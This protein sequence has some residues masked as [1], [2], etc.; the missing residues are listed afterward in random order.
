MTYSNTISSIA[1]V[2]AISM[3]LFTGCEKPGP[4][5]GTDE[6]VTYANEFIHEGSVYDIASV[7]RFDQDNNTIQFWISDKEGLTTIDQVADA[8]KHLV[9][10]VHKSYIGSRDRFTKAGS[11][12]RFDNLGFSAGDEGYAYADCALT[13]D[14]LTLKFAVQNMLTRESAADLDISGEY[15]GTYSTY[16]EAPLNNEWT[17]ERERTRLKEMEVIERE[18]GGEDTYKLYDITGQTAIHI[19]LPQA[20]RGLPT[21]FAIGTTALKGVSLSYNNGQT[22]PLDQAYGTITANFDDEESHAA[23]SFDISYG[24]IRI[25][26]EYAGAFNKKYIKA[27]RYIYESGS[28]YGTGYEGK[29]FFSEL[30]REAHG[31]TYIFKF[32]PQGTDEQWNKI[33]ILRISDHSLIGKTDIDLRNTAGWSFDFDRFQAITCYDPKNEGK[34]AAAE[35]SKLSI[36]ETEEGYYVDLELES[37][38]PY[39]LAGKPTT[40]DLHF[41]GPVTI[42]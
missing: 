9:I 15:R 28:A 41:E 40:I 31:Q 20:R 16:T 23:I 21:R 1:A 6:E 35:G 27:N 2:L 18:D 25:R 17:F 42:I 37:L 39:N 38:D 33:P 34:P 32:I 36:Y 7:V 4:A 30:R 3:T 11:F 10:S 5:T 26:A 8:G 13:G 14:T 22:I 12:V 19:T 29:Y 24:D